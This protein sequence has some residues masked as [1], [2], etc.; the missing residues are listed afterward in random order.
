MSNQTLEICGLCLN[1]LEACN[2]GGTAAAQATMTLSETSTTCTGF[3]SPKGTIDHTLDCPIHGTLPRPGAWRCSST[4]EW[5]ET[6]ERCGSTAYLVY[7]T[8]PATAPI[9]VYLSVDSALSSFALDD[10]DTY[11]L[12][13]GESSIDLS[14]LV[15]EYFMCERCETEYYEGSPEYDLMLED[16][17]LA[18]R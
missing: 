2:C 12:D 4:D 1:P 10:Y 13:I 14:L 17:R 11:D 3:I 8:A 15:P 6:G 9:S 16:F 5:G 7:G 18:R